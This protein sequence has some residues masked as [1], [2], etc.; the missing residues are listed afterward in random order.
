MAS[1][2]VQSQFLIYIEDRN[3][4]LNG[5]YWEVCSGVGS[6]A[7]SISTSN[8]RRRFN[9]PGTP[10]PKN[11]TISK[12]ANVKEDPLVEQ[13]CNTFCADEPIINGMTNSGAILMI[14]PLKPCAEEEPYP[15]TCKVFDIQPVDTSFWNSD[16][17]NTTDVSR[18]ELQLTCSSYKW[19]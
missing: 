18:V 1:N 19:S 12:A 15:Q 10:T 5:I 4:L 16:K 14:V 9:I 11:I 7:A 13:W 6:T 17:M 8:G 2:L 3:K